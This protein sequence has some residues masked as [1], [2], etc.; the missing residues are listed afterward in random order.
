MKVAG[1]IEP[2]PG[3][4]P[5][6]RGEVGMPV[7]RIT[8]RGAEVLREDAGWG[9]VP[10]LAARASDFPHVHPSC[11]LLSPPALRGW[12]NWGASGPIGPGVCGIL[13]P[14]FG[15]FPFHALG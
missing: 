11:K 14:N 15:E 3:A 4:D 8:G 10:V 6:G 7:R 9:T 13:D 12:G 5:M 1:W 2:D